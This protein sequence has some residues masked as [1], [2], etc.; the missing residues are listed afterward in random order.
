MHHLFIYLLLAGDGKLDGCKKSLGEVRLW[1]AGMRKGKERFFWHVG[2]RK[3]RIKYKK[4]G[5][6]QPADLD[7]EQECVSITTQPEHITWSVADC[8]DEMCFLCQTVKNM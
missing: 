5:Q 4:W 2:Q 6:G 8:H 3:K 7:D 1:T